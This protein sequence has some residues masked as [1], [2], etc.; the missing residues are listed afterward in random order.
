MGNRKRSGA[1]RNQFSPTSLKTMMK[2]KKQ[3]ILIMK[4]PNERL[5]RIMTVIGSAKKRHLVIILRRMTLKKTM[6][7]RILIMKAP[8]ERLKRIMTVIDSAKE[9]H[10]VIIL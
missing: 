1:W 2:S 10:L 9:R 6:K 3:R 4:A 5:K 8:N 7:Q